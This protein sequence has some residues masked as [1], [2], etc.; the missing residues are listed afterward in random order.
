MFQREDIKKILLILC[1]CF[2]FIGPNL[3]TDVQPFALGVSIIILFFCGGFNISNKFV[4][5]TSICVIALFVFSLFNVP[6]FDVLKRMFSYVSVILIPIAVEKSGIDIKSIRFERLMKVIMLVWMTVGVIQ[7]IGNK[8]FLNS[9]VPLMRTSEDR[10]VTSLSSEPSFYGYMC[11]FFFLIAKGFERNSRLFMTIELLQTLFIAQSATA[12]IYFV[13]YFVLWGISKL[14][15]LKKTGFVAITVMVICFMAA[16]VYVKNGD[17]SRRIISLAQ[18]ILNGTMTFENIGS[19]GVSSSIRWNA[20]ARAFSYRGIP[21]FMGTDQ[22][23]A[24]S[25]LGGA[26]FELGFLSIFM[27]LMIW[28]SILS[29]YTREEGIVIALAVT[30]AMVSAVQLSSPIFAFYMGYCQLRASSLDTIENEHYKEL[31]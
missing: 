10:G 26:F 21:N 24:L 2:P 17:A 30:I 31:A 1:C 9:I 20:I 13:C 18:D 16:I 22:Y 15:R 27:C 3:G 14:I 28:K 11:F 6:A 8:Y 12:A 4:V 23:V 5:P 19:T 25:G 29:A 7:T